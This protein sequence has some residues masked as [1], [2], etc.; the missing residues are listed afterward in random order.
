M[1][2][3]LTLV[4]L[5]SE[6]K[7]VVKLSTKEN[8]FIFKKK[9]MELITIKM[10]K[11]NIKANSEVGREMD[12]AKQLITKVS[13]EQIIMMVGA[14]CLIVQHTTKVISWLVGL[15]EMGFIF[16]P[17]VNLRIWTI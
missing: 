10:D 9:V 17:R 11:S 4:R 2:V 14:N 8:F 3:L 6:A 16:K 7:Q 1:M 5:W 12:G 13:S 15:M